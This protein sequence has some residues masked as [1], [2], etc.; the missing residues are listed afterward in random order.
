MSALSR[1]SVTGVFLASFG[2]AGCGGG[3]PDEGIPKDVDM[4]KSY[5][6]QVEM[7][8]MTPKAAFQAHKKAATPAP[9]PAK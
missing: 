3:G 2:L 4:S 6:P 8:G 7:P 5:T 9:A 1:V